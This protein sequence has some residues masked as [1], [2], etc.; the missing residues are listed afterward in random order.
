[1]PEESIPEVSATPP[2]PLYF[3]QTS[4]EEAFMNSGKSVRIF[5]A[6]EMQAQTFAVGAVQLRLP[7]SA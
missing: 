1:M 2:L 4:P 3:S 7:C 6:A 5:P